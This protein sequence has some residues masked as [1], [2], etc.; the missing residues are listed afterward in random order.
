M[1]RLR[2]TGS[3]DS[4]G[5]SGRPAL[6]TLRALAQQLLDRLSSVDGGFR[7]VEDGSDAPMHIGGLA[8]LQG[9]PPSVEEF[10]AHIESRLQPVPRYRQRVFHP[11]YQTGRPL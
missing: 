9:P 6:P 2:S 10:T 4:P 5:L 8:L 1:P 11:P 3:A 7:H